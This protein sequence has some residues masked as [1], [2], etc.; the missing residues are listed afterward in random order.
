[1]GLLKSERLLSAADNQTGTLP[2]PGVQ[3]DT[4]TKPR[5]RAQTNNKQRRTKRATWQPAPANQGLAG[6]QLKVAF[7]G[8]C[9]A[10]TP[11]QTAT[12]AS[13]EGQAYGPQNDTL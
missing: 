6:D 2:V 7:V 8:Q 1:M 3:S 13:T 10:P 5:A 4:E 12:T 11:S 9:V